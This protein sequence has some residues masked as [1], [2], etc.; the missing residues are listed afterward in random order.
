[1]APDLA[2]H[3]NYRRIGI[4]KKMSDLKHK[5]QIGYNTNL[6]YYIPGNPILIRRAIQRGRPSFPRP[7]LNLVRIDD[8]DLHLRMM[9]AEHAWL[10]RYGFH[11]S[12][13]IHKMRYALSHW[14]MFNK[15]EQNYSI[16]E[17]DRFDE[18][19]N[20]FLRE[21]RTNYNF[22][23]E[24]NQDYLNWRYSDPRGGNYIR[25]KAENDER[26]LG[27]IILRINR[28]K[29]EYP[30]G[31]IVD[32]LTI[33]DRIDVA[34]DLITNAIRLFDNLSV[35]M[36][37]YWGVQKHPHESLLRKHGFLKTRKEPHIFF[38]PMDVGK[39]W[40]QFRVSPPHQLFFQIGDTDAI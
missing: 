30:I 11:L 6:T 22:I 14:H 33:P 4:S 7:I 29:R 25:K 38:N 40:D 32:L 37:Q 12:K 8:I 36:I 24:R 2:V 19:I 1:M 23:V 39:E 13:F 31:Y 20:S 28:Y 3:P 9:P 10:K 35:N 26:I 17:I 34:N 27:Y 18:R 15:S 21:I 16:T 5:F